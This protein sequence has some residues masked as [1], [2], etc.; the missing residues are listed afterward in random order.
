MSLG[1]R[2]THD[3]DLADALERMLAPR[4]ATLL[5]NRGPGH[6]ARITDVDAPLATRLTHGD[7]SG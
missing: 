3:D 4:L 6:C 2:E 5:R 7:G 1:L